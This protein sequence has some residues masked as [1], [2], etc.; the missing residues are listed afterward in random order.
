[1]YFSLI[2]PSTKT[3][4]IKADKVTL[5]YNKWW[6]TINHTF[7][8]VNSMKLREILPRKFCDILRQTHHNTCICQ[9]G[10]HLSLDDIPVHIQ[11]H[12]YNILYTLPWGKTHHMKKHLI[13]SVQIPEFNSSKQGSSA[14]RTYRQMTY[15]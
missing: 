15:L 8:K 11:N 1:M 10:W 12:L 7:F 5:Q 6:V 3:K 2:W 13:S 14:Y 4:E 9:G